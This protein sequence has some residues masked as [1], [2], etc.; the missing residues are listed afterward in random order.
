M[1]ETPAPE[2]TD[3]VNLLVPFSMSRLIRAAGPDAIVTDVT[4]RTRDGVLVKI[5]KNSARRQSP[6]S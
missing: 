4:L 2:R 1:A 3:A 6:S 5:G